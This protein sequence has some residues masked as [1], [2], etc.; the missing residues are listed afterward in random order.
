MFLKLALSLLEG[1]QPSCV[2]VIVEVKD[3]ALVFV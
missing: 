3:T 1:G 2:D